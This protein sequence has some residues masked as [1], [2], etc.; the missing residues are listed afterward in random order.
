MT[1]SPLKTLAGT[2][3]GATMIAT[4]AAKYGVHLSLGISK[5]FLNGASTLADKMTGSSFKL[6]I[7]DWMM[8]ETENLINKGFDK[9]LK[10]QQTLKGK[11]R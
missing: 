4:K 11:T 10:A 7:G 2:L 1:R 9:L 3:L 6:G 8:K 5:V